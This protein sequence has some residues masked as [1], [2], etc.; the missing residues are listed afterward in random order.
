MDI[1]FNYFYTV[2]VHL[3]WSVQVIIGNRVKIPGSFR[4]CK[5]CKAFQHTGHFSFKEWE[6]VE[7]RDKPEDLPMFNLPN[8]SE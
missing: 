3:D 1:I 4:C 8:G 2:L 6:G 7:K 5:S